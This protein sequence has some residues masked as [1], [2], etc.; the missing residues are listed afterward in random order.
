MI[1]VAIALCMALVL[2]GC[3][4]YPDAHS[5]PGSSQELG[6]PFSEGTSLLLLDV[7]VL[8]NTDKT[9]VDH[10]MSLTSGRD[11]ST[12]RAQSSGVYCQEREPPRPPPTQPVYCYRSLASVNCFESPVYSQTDHLVGMDYVVASRR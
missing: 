5:I 6:F 4:S 2:S 10:V 7:A 9:I 12:I 1:R 3:K 8:I 11:C